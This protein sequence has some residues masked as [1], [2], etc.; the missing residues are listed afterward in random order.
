[1]EATHPTA[2]PI[3]VPTSA[4]ADSC[5]FLE[6]MPAELRNE[7]YELAF[8]RDEDPSQE[9]QLFDASPPRKG[10]LLSCHQIYNE[11]KDYY[12]QAYQK[13][14]RTSKFTVLAKHANAEQIEQAHFKK[15]DV[16]NINTLHLNIESENNPRSRSCPCAYHYDFHFDR[17]TLEMLVTVK[18]CG[19][20]FLPGRYRRD[21]ALKFNQLQSGEQVVWLAEGP[22]SPTNTTLRAPLHIQLAYYA[23]FPQRPYSYEWV[24]LETLP[25]WGRQSEKARVVQ[26]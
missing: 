22:S 6:K 25:V 12:I 21:F 2:S 16:N 7:I 9:V 8:S 4:E 5:P 26:G 10:L 23:T 19:S 11:S 18:P 1:M 20:G 14:W 17:N 24:P 13:Y 3:P 15:E